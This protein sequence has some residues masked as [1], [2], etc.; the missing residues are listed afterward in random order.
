M[1]DGNQPVMT[2]SAKAIQAASA[3]SRC[4]QGGCPSCVKAG[5]PVLVMR[6]GVVARPYMTNIQE[7]I[8][9][10]LQGIGMPKLKYLDYA[11]RTLREGYLYAF[12]EK[13]HTPEIKAQNGWQVNLVDE[14]GY[15]TP[16]P[17]SPLPLF[18]VGDVPQFSCERTAGYAAAMLFVIPDARNTGRVWVAFSENPW[19]PKVLERYAKDEAL[20]NKRMTCIDAQAASCDAALPLTAESVEQLIYDYSYQTLAMAGDSGPY[21]R[22]SPRTVGGVAVELKIPGAGASKVRSESAEDLIAAAKE[23]LSRGRDEYTESDLLM[24]MTDDVVGI[25][26]ETA[27][28]RTTHFRSAG[29]YVLGQAGG[30]AEKADWMLKS[31]LSIEGLMASLKQ[32]GQRKQQEYDDA[33]CSRYHNTSMMHRDFKQLQG[34]KLLPPEAEFIPGTTVM[35]T[36]GMPSIPDYDVPGTVVLP[37]PVKQA[38]EQC[39]KLRRKLRGHNAKADYR[40]FLDAYEAHARVDAEGLL[41][42]EGDHLAC[43]DCASRKFL[44]QYDFDVSDTVSGFFYTSTTARIL[45]GGHITGNSAQGNVD[46][47]SGD[48]GKGKGADWYSRYL[49]DDPALRENIL[50][51]ALLGNTSQGFDEWLAKRDGHF[52]LMRNVL[53]NVEELASDPAAA[54]WVKLAG[55]HSG[56]MRILASGYVSALLPAVAG[57]VSLLQLTGRLTPTVLSRMTSLVALMSNAGARRAGATLVGVTMPLYRAL[58]VWR[59]MMVNAQEAAVVVGRATSANRAAVI[60]FSSML[61]TIGA[62]SVA[63][64]LVEVYMWVD[65]AP[66]EMEAWAQANALKSVALTGAARQAT[67]RAH[68]AVRLM[69]GVVSGAWTQAA[70]YIT[71]NTL[72]H[73][74]GTTG[75]VLAN[76]TAVMAGGS[77]VLSV[78][79]VMKNYE[80]FSRGNE[81]ERAEAVIGMLT[82]A[83]AFSGAALT[84]QEQIFRAQA[85]ELRAVSVKAL[86]G[87]LVS[88]ASFIDAFVCVVKSAFARSR[89]DYAGAKVLRVQALVLGGAGIAAWAA[90]AGSSA[91]IIGIGM[92]GWG[93]ILALVGIGL[94]FLYHYFK[95]SPL[96]AWGARSFWG[97]NKG[98]GFE[99]LISEQWNLDMLQ[100]GVK[101]EFE[102]KARTDINTPGGKGIFANI[103]PLTM[104]RNVIDDEDRGKRFGMREGWVRL[105]LPAELKDV[106]RI[107]IAIY[108]RPNVGRGMVLLGAYMSEGP[109]LSIFESEYPEVVDARDAVVQLGDERVDGGVFELVRS[110]GVPL[111]GYRDAHAIVWLQEVD[112]SGE[113]FGTDI[114]MKLTDDGGESWH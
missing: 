9:P 35:K 109:R 113:Y 64:A 107:C 30:N 96:E 88:V 43:L 77:G 45:H 52:G 46:A 4:S 78:L 50:L 10:L 101:V 80:Q 108:A 63:D 48:L 99:G 49:D 53:D 7:R 111:F 66:R 100:V 85:N 41:A 36:A 104:L 26:H 42:M 55:K 110:C 94:V 62:T 17:L 60:N 13:A 20:R 65:K 14:G 39:E 29:D 58:R 57:A 76:G 105:V 15:L 40:K 51:R 8:S 91:T 114:K 67:G 19:A 2:Y 97:D 5:L 72:M 34:L 24:V 3:A 112:K 12:Y 44:Y 87:R 69:P 86:S 90:A 61:R 83:L 92:T 18:C 81:A 32:A 21:Q 74:A 73:L 22:R 37:S 38:E 95:D 75:K 93:L 79:S 54:S 33:G 59:R 102:L 106:I 98:G 68:Y 27:V 84:I 89:G 47:E 31:A 56:A 11:A 82:G 16:V 70:R 6:P 103:F 23:M 28:L 71:G 1:S 25:A